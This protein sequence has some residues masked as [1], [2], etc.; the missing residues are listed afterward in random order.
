[1]AMSTWSR[2]TR[3]NRSS[4]AQAIRCKQPDIC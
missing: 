4:S 2:L 3:Y 1:M